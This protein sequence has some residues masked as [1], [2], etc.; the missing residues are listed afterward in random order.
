MDA[1]KKANGESEQDNTFK[2]T[3]NLNEKCNS[4]VQFIKYK[5]GPGKFYMV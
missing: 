3:G 1:K 2:C 4:W 5:L